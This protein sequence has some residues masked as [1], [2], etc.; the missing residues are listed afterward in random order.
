[1]MD[2]KEVLLQWITLFLVRK[3]AAGATTSGGAVTCANKSAIKRRN[4]LNKHLKEEL[5]K[6][7]IKKFGKFKVYSSFK[8]NIWSADLPDFQ[9]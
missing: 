2:I 6:P 9:L 4:I 3:P 7:V 8:I 1:M 5:H